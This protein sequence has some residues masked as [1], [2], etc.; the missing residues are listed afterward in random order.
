MKE[1]ARLEG[2]YKNYSELAPMMIARIE[3]G[4]VPSDR[5]LARKYD[6]FSAYTKLICCAFSLELDNETITGHLSSS[7]EWLLKQDSPEFDARLQE[8]YE[9]LTVLSMARIYGVDDTTW[10]ALSGYYKLKGLEDSLFAFLLTG[11][12]ADVHSKLYFGDT[13]EGLVGAILAKNEDDAEVCLKAYLENWYK[14]HKGTYWHDSHKRKDH[15]YFGYW[16][17]EAAAV[18]KMGGV[19]L[20]K[21]QDFGQYFPL[22]SLKS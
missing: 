12:I 6:I 3:A 21:I 1:R 7:I 22:R 19:Q 18:A 13:Y 15:S 10:V 20:E 14:K 17:F 8:Y 9:H 11:D 4:K 16:S 5:V 2:C